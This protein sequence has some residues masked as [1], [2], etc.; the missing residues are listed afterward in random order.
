VPGPVNVKVAPSIVAG[1]IAT[2]KVAVTIVLGQTPAAALSG[3]TGITVEGVKSELTPGL[4]HPE[5]RMS[6]KSAAKQTV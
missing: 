2:L 4:Q 1:F 3:A 6:S 5:L